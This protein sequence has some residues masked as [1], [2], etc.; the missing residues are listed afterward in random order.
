M[1][2]QIRIRQA[3]FEDI[4][5][6]MPVFE[7]ARA[8]IAALGIDQWQDGYPSREHIEADIV[9]DVG[10]VLV[11]PD[12]T[13]QG[14][15][16]MLTEP[17]PTYAEIFEGAWLT[18]GAYLTVHRVAMSDALRGRGGAAEAMQYA[19]CRAVRQGLG[20]V[21][22]D[23]HKGN[24]RMRKF[25]EK[26]GF[27]ACGIIYLESGAQRVAYQ[28]DLRPVL[29]AAPTVLYEDRSMM[30]CQKPV[31][32]PSQPDPAHADGSDLYSRIIAWQMACGYAP[33]AYLVHRLDTAT[34]GAILF[35]KDRESAARLGGMVVG[36]Q[37]FKQYLAV[38]HGTLA[39]RE[40]RMDDY[41]YHDKAQ[42]KAFVVD[43]ARKG[44]K[45]A[46]LRY[47]TLAQNGDC[48]LIEVTLE[49]GRTHQ[50]RAQFSHAGHPL[51][52]DGKYGSRE[53][54]CTTAL[55]AYKLGVI[56][57]AKRSY[58]EAISMPPNAYPWNLFEINGG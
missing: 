39:Q 40:G 48:S 52:G 10:R 25:L 29:A 51:L 13:V 18:D 28:K 23:T 57:P 38:V 21:R 53:K 58:Q 49:T 15:F 17:E 33:A 46:S 24:V 16:A 1:N 22:I 3:T 8:A 42:N 54:S 4:E 44:V 43:S 32:Q 27:L 14:Y 9:K 5:A 30:I 19:I 6:I 11:A 7:Q 45:L 55:W 12:G 26:Q 2:H 41:L 34:G 56:S 36:K 35:A 37:I 50:I 31:G 20:S 47:R